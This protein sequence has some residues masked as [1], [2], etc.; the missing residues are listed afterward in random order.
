M[1]GTPTVDGGMT[2]AQ[3]AGLQQ[4]EREWQAEMEADKYDQA[5]A[6]E[7]EQRDYDASQKESLEAQKNAEELAIEQGELAIQSEVK[8]Q[9]DAEDD[10]DNMD[11]DFY[12]SLANN[13]SMN[14]DRPE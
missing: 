8:A 1:G 3:Y 11:A 13:S 12:D 2:E 5:M 14:E 9:V 10:E 6:Y 7:K 4:E